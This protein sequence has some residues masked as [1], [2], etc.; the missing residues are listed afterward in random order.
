MSTRPSMTISVR[1]ERPVGQVYAYLAN[2]T[3]FTVWASGLGRL[4]HQSGN[5]WRAEI[6]G[7]GSAEIRFSTQ[8]AYGIVDHLVLLPDGRSVP[9]PMRVIQNGDGAEV[10]FTLFQIEGMSDEVFAGDADWVARD[11]A[12]LKAVLEEG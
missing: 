9:V 1:I 7:G 11:L 10:L 6:T 5:R 4:T 12:Q 8:N 2:P 3:N